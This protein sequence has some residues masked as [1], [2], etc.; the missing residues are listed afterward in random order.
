MPYTIFVTG[1]S[2]FI[3]ASFVRHALGAGH[4][5]QLL[6]RSPAS[7]ERARRWGADP[8]PGDLGIAGSWQEVAARAEVVVHLAQPE[9]YGRRITARRAAAFRDQRLRMDANLLDCLRA[10]TVQRIVYVGGTSYYGQQG[11]QLVDEETTPRPRGWG[12]YIAPAI[13]ALDA[14]CE[15]GL[16]ILQA[17][18]AWVY[19]P[20]SWYAQYQLE[21]LLAGRS[22]VNLRG[23]DPAISV[24][25]VEDVAR[26]LLHLIDHGE[27]GKRYFIA[28][29]RP[30]PAA[31][32]AELTARV[33]NVAIRIRRLPLLVARLAV[34]RIIAESLTTEA[35]L[36]NERLKKTGFQ[37]AFPTTADGVPDVVRR[38][39]EHRTSPAG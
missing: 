29:D 1:G 21:P 35:R 36:S 25:H 22:L 11:G 18:P 12:P 9:T 15:R 13:E 6:T 32:L 10:N 8:V 4:R 31:R 7:A 33:M 23:H 37:F 17:F 27:A 20:G 39:L 16:P 38:W 34:G 5:L 14:Y 28:D 3:G 26:A 30:L 2:G 19:G 24:V